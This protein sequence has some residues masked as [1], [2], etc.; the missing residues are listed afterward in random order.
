M[1]KRFILKLKIIDNRVWHQF[2][3]QWEIWFEYIKLCADKKSYKQQFCTSKKVKENEIQV[4]HRIRHSFSKFLS[5]LW[6]FYLKKNKT[7]TL[8][9]YSR[10]STTKVRGSRC[11]STSWSATS[12]SSAT[13]C[14]LTHADINNITCEIKCLFR[15]SSIKMI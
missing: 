5:F 1:V 3:N 10:W 11:C 12:Y 8:L 2:I 7:N 6:F 9:V 13:F 15:F 4:M 14:L